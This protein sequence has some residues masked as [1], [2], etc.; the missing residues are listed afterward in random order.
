M[1]LSDVLENSAAAKAGLKPNDILLEL[2]GQPVPSKFDDF[3]RQLDTIKPN[4]TIEAV[5]LRKGRKETVKGLSLPDMSQPATT[6]GRG[7]P[8]RPAFEPKQLVPPPKPPEKAPEAPP[9]PA[10]AEGDGKALIRTVTR[11]GDEF[12][13]HHRDGDFVIVIK[14][15]VEEGHPKAERIT[16]VDGDAQTFN[17]I[18]DLPKK[19][20]T[21]VHN[22]LTSVTRGV[23][24]RTN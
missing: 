7:A 16:I 23:K 9:A 3:A 11:N 14:G 5:V 15:K 17:G 10:A 6:P 12:T 20:K 21:T 4:E 19:Y 2:N 13:A 8:P 22:L 1:V 24:F 18:E